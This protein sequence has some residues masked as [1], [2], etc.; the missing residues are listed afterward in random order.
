MV[1][2]CVICETRLRCDD[3][4]CQRW[5][6]SC[7][8]VH[9]EEHLREK[10]ERDASRLSSFNEQR[11]HQSHAAKSLWSSPV[12]GVVAV[13]RW[14]QPQA[15]LIVK[16]NHWVN[17]LCYIR[18]TDGGKMRNDDLCTIATC[19]LKLRLALGRHC[20]SLD[21][22]RLS[23]AGIY[24]LV[25]GAS[26]PEPRSKAIPGHTARD[27]EAQTAGRSLAV[28]RLTALLLPREG[29]S[30]FPDRADCRMV[31]A[32]G[33]LKRGKYDRYAGR[34]MKT[35]LAARVVVSTA[36]SRYAISPSTPPL[37]REIWKIVSAWTFAQVLSVQRGDPLWNDA[38]SAL[39]SAW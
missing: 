37:P 17:S 5:R 36:F 30:R 19:Q 7:C 28:L 4:T 22:E 24:I 14:T 27:W 2:Y 35:R 20:A 23:A 8:A 39:A 31:T 25:A 13:G 34:P 10:K 33:V 9:W 15:I 16:A 32:K 1:R 18:Q 12:S 29:A 3:P 6:A 21:M 38:E 26:R 11:A